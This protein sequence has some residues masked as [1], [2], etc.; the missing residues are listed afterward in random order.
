M[1][2]QMTPFY[3]DLDIQCKDIIQHWDQQLESVEQQTAAGTESRRVKLR[4]IPLD[5]T[6]WDMLKIANQQL[7][8]FSLS[9]AYECSFMR[10]DPGDH[11]D[12]PHWDCEEHRQENQRKLSFTLMLNDDYQGGELDVVGEHI[13]AKTGRLII[14]PSYLMHRVRPVTEGTRYVIVG[15]LLGDPWQ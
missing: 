12:N 9:D 11:Y 7:Y 8:K 10:Y 15:W 14:F 3:Q 13:T 1:M 6:L 4:P 2:N 5:T